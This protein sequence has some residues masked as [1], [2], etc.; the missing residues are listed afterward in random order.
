MANRHIE[1]RKQSNSVRKTGTGG[2]F[3]LVGLCAFEKCI[4]KGL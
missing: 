3:F 2:V 1:K 4:L